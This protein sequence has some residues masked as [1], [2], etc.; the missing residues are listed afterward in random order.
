MKLTSTLAFL[1]LSIAAIA[2]PTND[3]PCNAE[4]I[5]VDGAAAEGDN[6]DATADTD[7]VLPPASIGG[8]SCIT[9]WCNDDPAVQNSMWYSFVAPANG[10]VVISTCITG[11]TLDTQIALWTAENCADYST[12][13]FVAANDDMEGGCTD[14]DVYSSTITMDG[15]TP[16]STYLIQ[17]DGWGGEFGP[18]FLSVN[19][20]QPSALVNFIH[21]SAD[22]SVVLVD[23]RL[24]GELIL[25]DFAFLTCSQYIPVDA[26]GEHVVSIHPSTSLDETIV[27]ASLE[28]NLNSTLNYEIAIS[29]LLNPL[30]FSNY[31]PLELLLFEGAQQY[32]S[33]NEAMPIHFLNA[34]TD[35][36][37]IQLTNVE[38]DSILIS[39]LS[40]GNF[41]LEGYQ[42]FSDNFTMGV[43]I[44]GSTG[45]E[46][47]FDYYCIPAAIAALNGLGYT[48]AAAGFTFP[49]ANNN[50]PFLD[51]YYVDAQN[52]TLVPVTLG[53][54]Q[55]Q[56]N[57]NLCTATALVINDTP[58]MADN[59]FATIEE[60][61]SMPANLPGNDPESDCLN[62]WCDG[63]LDNTLWFSFTAP[64][65]GCVFISTCFEDGVIDTQIALCT[66]DDCTNPSAINYIAAND[67]MEAACNGNEYSSE[68]TYCGLTPGANYY[69]QTDGY[70]G[71][72]GAFY[73]QVTE[74]LNVQEVTNNAV[75][76]YPNPAADKLFVEGIEIGAEIEIVYLTGQSV[77]RGSYSRNGIDIASLPAGSYV[78]RANESNTS[79]AFI[80]I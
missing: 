41:N 9:S 38:L 29:G 27:L 2:Q 49:M 47:V 24:D 4:L 45:F 42:L 34:S 15:L 58:T 8:N 68:L 46:L 19:T 51:F 80:K 28:I 44:S 37:I 12:Y 20:G 31:E 62:A 7:E 39:D 53:S 72:L 32:A 16:G 69:I 48:I 79:V 66:A 76:I 64:A 18:F 60:N 10:A 70:D 30:G 14:G 74:P 3:T 71:E 55:F 33:T 1:L 43:F 75:A 35:A 54:C 52:G 78:L 26:T 56:D 67:D 63:T 25:D 73:I 59:S 40:Y 65:S 6:T 5:E 61:E 13:S 17:V 77:Y 22:P 21:V 36:E 23:V 57:D 11:S 50:G